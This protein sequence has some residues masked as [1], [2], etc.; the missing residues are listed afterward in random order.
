MSV[1]GPAG[2]RF[3]CACKRIWHGS[4]HSRHVHARSA[5][6]AERKPVTHHGRSRHDL[7]VR[8]NGPTDP[9]CIGRDQAHEAGH[10]TLEWLCA[11]RFARPGSLYAEHQL[12]ACRHRHPRQFRRVEHRAGRG[13]HH[14]EPGYPVA[15]GR[16]LLGG[17]AKP[18]APG[19]RPEW[20]D[21]KQHA[22][23]RH[24]RVLRRTVD[25]HRQQRTQNSSPIP[26]PFGVNVITI[27]T[28]L[29]SPTT[30]SSPVAGAGKT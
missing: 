5:A 15:T 7:A 10:I 19:N 30:T 12:R 14:H 11:I 26:T 24:N 17:G 6:R 21:R 16:E 2:R 1:D 4:S 29:R 23:G 8:P 27:R 28:T 9:T 3:E 13:Y 18:D 20:H 22:S 25:D